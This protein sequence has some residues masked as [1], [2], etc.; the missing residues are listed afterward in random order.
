MAGR[1]RLQRFVGYRYGKNGSNVKYHGIA[2]GLDDLGRDII[3]RRSGAIEVVQCKRWSI[4]KTIHE[5]H[6]FQ[7]FGTVTAY[8]IDRPG[9]PVSGKFVT[10]TRLSERALQ[11]ARQLGLDV[12]QG[13]ALMLTTPASS[14]TSRRRAKRS[15]TSPWISSTTAL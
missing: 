2:K 10:T 1:P 9:D 14:A 13:Y 11:F 15:T 4:Q 8:R 12:A 6:V 5:Q 7:L 3:A